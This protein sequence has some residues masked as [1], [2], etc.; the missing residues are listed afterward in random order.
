MINFIKN[1]YKYF[2]PI[3]V[4][5]AS[6]IPLFFAS[7]YAPLASIPIVM[8]GTIIL[9]Y[10]TSH[11]IQEELYIFDKGKAFIFVI[12]PVET[13]IV[14]WGYLLNNRNRAE[15]FIKTI[16]LFLILIIYAILPVIFGKSKINK[17]RARSYYF[18]IYFL[19]SSFV[20][21]T[22][23]NQLLRII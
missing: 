18:I 17:S 9:F 14:L 12:F 4:I 15:I 10:F 20:T 2:I 6:V 16:C 19:L 5:I 22:Q 21:I 7:I 23:V 11:K 13:F 3:L 1:H 8:L